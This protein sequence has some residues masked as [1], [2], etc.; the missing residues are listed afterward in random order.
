MHAK[1]WPSL[2]MFTVF[3]RIFGDFPAKH[4]AFT[5]YIYG[6]WPTLCKLLLPLDVDRAS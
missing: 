4:N 2:Y 3:D 6:F 1:G 5:P